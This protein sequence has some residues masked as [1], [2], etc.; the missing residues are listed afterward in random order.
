MGLTVATE[1]FIAATSRSIEWEIKSVGRPSATRG[2]GQIKKIFRSF[3]AAFDCLFASRA[4]VKSCYMPL[5]AGIT[6]VYNI[7][8]AVVCK[9]RGIPLLVHHHSYSYLNARSRMLAFLNRLLSEKDGHI[10][11]SDTM[12]AA[13]DQQYLRRAQ[14]IVLPNSYAIST[15]LSPSKTLDRKSNAL[16][17]GHL[18][19]L[20]IEKGLKTVLDA[21]A[22]LRSQKSDSELHLAGPCSG[23]QEQQLLQSAKKQFG[24]SVQIHGPLYGE[25]KDD[26]FRSIDYFWFPSEY[27]NE[28]QPIVLVEALAF[29]IPIVSMKR[30]CI[31]WLL[32]DAGIAATDR[33][34]FIRTAV[35]QVVHH[36]S[37]TERLAARERCLNRYGRLQELESTGFSDAIR[38]LSTQSQ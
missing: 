12:R 26:F 38:F 19:N 33:Q 22:E 16:R 8:F 1:R 5:S 6:M 2:G 34:Q 15:S 27:V 21:F 24:D 18:S 4:R 3:K 29:G 7:G 20:S 31:E 37:E 28:A 32:G 23:A 13:Y 36:S 35:E 9:V 11:L 10:F 14:S 25:S 17:I 30:G